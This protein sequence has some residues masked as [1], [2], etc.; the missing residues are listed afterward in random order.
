MIYSPCT[1]GTFG[2]FDATDKCVFQPRVHV[3]DNWGWCTGYCNVGSVDGTDECYDG[4]SASNECDSEECPGGD[5]SVDGDQCID[6]GASLIVN[7]WI[8]YDGVIIVDWAN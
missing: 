5:Y 7:P 8:N 2:G 4:G 6:D 1:G 3:K